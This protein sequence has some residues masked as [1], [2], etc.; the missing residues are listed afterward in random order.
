M[1]KSS[2]EIDEL[3]RV[4]KFVHALEELSVAQGVRIDSLDGTYLIV[5]GRDTQ[6]FVHSTDGSPYVVSAMVSL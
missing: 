4:V 5:D 3:N 6:L 1:T 2:F